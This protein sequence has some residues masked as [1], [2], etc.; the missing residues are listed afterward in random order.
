MTG[1]LQVAQSLR[2]RVS[3][4]QRPLRAATSLKPPAFPGDIYRCA[5]GAAAPADRLVMS[6]IILPFP[7]RGRFD[8]RVEREA[9]DVGWF[10]LLPDRSHGW[11]HG[12]FAAAL[13]EARELAS[14]FGVSSFRARGEVHEL[15]RK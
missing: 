6:A 10:V 7:P 11:L 13:N 8:I 9:G 5:L 2:G 4:P 14:G 3:D 1:H 12:D 15:D